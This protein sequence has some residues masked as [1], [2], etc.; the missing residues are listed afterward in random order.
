MAGESIVK[1]FIYIYVHIENIGNRITLG[2]YYGDCS[3]IKDI[4]I[5][6]V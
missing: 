6:F 2:L 4:S 1:S 5:I 3:L